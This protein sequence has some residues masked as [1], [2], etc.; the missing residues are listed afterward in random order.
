VK[1]KIAGIKVSMF[2]GIRQAPS[3]LFLPYRPGGDD[4]N[5][6]GKKK[7]KSLVRPT[8]SQICLKNPEP[9]FFVIAYR[10]LIEA[11]KAAMSALSMAIEWLILSR[12][13]RAVY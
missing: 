1:P 5:V 7:G 3:L 4:G 8:F 6:D 13:L 11:F 10:Y 12:F 9:C 2:T